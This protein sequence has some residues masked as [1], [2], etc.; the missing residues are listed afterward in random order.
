MEK[1]LLI[2]LPRSDDATEY[3]SNFS[4]PIIDVCSKNSIKVK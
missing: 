1:G 2:T 4:K 3:L